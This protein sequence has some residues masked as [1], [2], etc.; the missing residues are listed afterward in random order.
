MPINEKNEQQ[1][2]KRLGKMFQTQFGKGPESIYV[3][4]TPPFVTIHL[5]GFLAPMEEVLLHQDKQLQLEQLREQ[6]MIKILPVIQQIVEEET[7]ETVLDM[8]YDW[9]FRKNKKCTGM[10]WIALDVSPEQLDTFSWPQEL[11]ENMFLREIIA[12]SKKVQKEPVETNLFWLSP[13]LILVERIGIFVEIENA[14]IEQNYGETLKIVKRPL[15]KN[16]FAKHVLESLL[17]QKIQETFVDWHFQKDKGY[18]LIGLEKP[19]ENKKEKNQ[20]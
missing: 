3:M 2:A 16:L 20:N 15:E 6:M 11:N 9:N 7:D 13:R 12:L 14:L 17:Q 1:A 18:L 10:V 4:I 19:Q 5:Q 8:Y